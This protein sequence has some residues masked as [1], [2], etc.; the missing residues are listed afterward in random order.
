MWDNLIW[1]ESSGILSCE[2]NFQRM[3][4]KRI[5]FYRLRPSEV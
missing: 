5:I 1:D 4:S 2:I 3:A